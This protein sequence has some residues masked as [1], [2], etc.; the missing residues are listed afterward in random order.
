MLFVCE[1]IDWV[2]P[3]R[4]VGAESEKTVVR[5]SYGKD[6]SDERRVYCHFKKILINHQSS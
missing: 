6:L 1:Q 2:K 4:E 3:G 5:R